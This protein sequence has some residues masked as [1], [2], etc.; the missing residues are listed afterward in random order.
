[1]ILFQNDWKKYPSAIVDVDT[2]NKS[3]LRLAG[4]YKAMGIHNNAFPLALLNPA[5]KGVDPHAKDL[6][7]EQIMMIAEE[8]KLNPWYF[9]REVIRVPAPGSPEPVRYIASRANISMYWLFFNHITSFIVQIRQTGKSVAADCLNIYLI[10]VGTTNTDIHLL[11]RNDDLRVKNIKRIKEIESYLPS[12]LS[13]KSRADSNNTEKITCSRLGNTYLTA[14]G[15]AS[16][17]GARN[18][19]RGMTIA[20]HHV[21]EMAYVHNIDIILPALLASGGAA[22][23]SAKKAGG[24]YGTIFTSTPGFLS[25]R[26]GRFA[27]KIY[28]SCFRWTEKLLDC[29]DLEDATAFIKKNSPKGDVQVLCEFNHRQLGYTDEWLRTKIAE[30]LSEGENALADYLNVWPQGSSGSPIRKDLLERIVKSAVGDPFT[31]ISKYGYLLRWYVTED[32]VNN[33]LSNRKLIMGLDTSEA[34]GNDDI[35]MVILD[36][37]TGEVVGTGQFN[38]TNVILFSEWLA[39]MLI[40][41]P[42]ITL[43][44]ERRSSGGAILDNLLLILDAKGIDPFKRIFNWIVNDSDVNQEY[45]DFLNKPHPFRSQDQINKYRKH[46]GYATAGAGR[47]ARDNLY[48]AAFS[49][50]TKYL[51][52]V[53]RDKTLIGQLAGLVT[54]N[55]RIDHEEGEHDDMVISLLL[56]YYFLTNAKNINYYGLSSRKVLMF[57]RTN[58]DGT[59]STPETIV[60]KTEQSE[61]RNKIEDLINKLKESN[62]IYVSKQITQEIRRLYNLIDDEAKI[63]FNIETLLEEI[64]LNK[65]KPKTRSLNM[66]YFY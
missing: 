45:H 36:V 22:R 26:S 63:N 24:Y 37:E 10:D 27:Y 65:K 29:Y 8:C 25:S 7:L 32:E 3:F 60:K 6:S 15:Q 58:E 20:I 5:L 40:E 56:A 17:Q 18:V 28:N 51:C 19:G 42:N 48:G 33:K 35:C 21:D 2:P 39:E 34:I 55:G 53:I 54:K 50:T 41:F 46:I 62:N 59:K 12:Y 64:E 23:D 16:V 61:I 47:A 30:S 11:T 52:D 57:L 31:T 66:N 13:L 1:M 44:P 43:I 49:S 38:E 4:I 9:F 14:V